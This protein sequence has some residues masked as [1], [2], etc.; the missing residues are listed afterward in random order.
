M[1]RSR[2]NWESLRSHNIRTRRAGL[3]IIC[4][5]VT[6]AKSCVVTAIASRRGIKM[7]LPIALLI[8]SIHCFGQAGGAE[9]FG[10]VQD[11]SGLPSQKA[12]VQAQQPG[13]LAQF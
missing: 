13:T 6:D 2:K 7:R 1:N 5:P 11:P 4:S 12:R 9:L 10:S 8:C 3:W